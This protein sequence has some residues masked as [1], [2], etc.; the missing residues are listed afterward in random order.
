ME[1]KER[2]IAIEIGG[3]EGK[4]FKSLVAQNPEK[5]FIGVKF[6]INK[7]GDDGRKNYW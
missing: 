1:N 6:T 2:K 7:N 3:G 5:T 4:F